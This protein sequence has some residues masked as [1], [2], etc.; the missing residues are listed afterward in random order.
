MIN[1]IPGPKDRRVTLIELTEKGERFYSVCTNSFVKY[2]KA[3]FDELPQAQIEGFAAILEEYTRFL[4]GERIAP[5]AN[6]PA[7]RTITPEDI[8]AINEVPEDK[9]SLTDADVELDVK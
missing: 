9:V 5:P 1:R 2:M 4:S 8:S 3:V 6:I 7:A